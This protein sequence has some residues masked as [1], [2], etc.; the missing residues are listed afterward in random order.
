MGDNVK[1]NNIQIKNAKPQDTTGGI[2]YLI[3]AALDWSV[4]DGGSVRA[5]IDASK[6]ETKAAWLE[7]EQQVLLALEDAE[8]ALMR[9]GKEWQTY[10]SLQ[11]ARASR[12]Q[13]FDIA[14]L[15]YEAGEESFIVILDAERALV[16]VDDALVQSETRILTALTQ[17]YKALGGGWQRPVA[18]NPKTTP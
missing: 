2:R 15:R 5:R 3:G 11:T 9:Y 12:Q 13:A 17:V 7:Y 10:R 16:S 6:A 18:S 8:G 4:L 14:R 1:L